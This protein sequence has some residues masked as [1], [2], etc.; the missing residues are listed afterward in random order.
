MYKIIQN[1][2]ELLEIEKGWDKLAKKFSHPFFSFNWY[3]S[4]ISSFYNSEDVYILVTYDGK[5][6]TGIAPLIKYGKNKISHL[7]IAGY[8]SHFEPCSLLY[9]DDKSKNY[10]LS[11]LLSLNVPI[12][13][14]RIPE[15]YHLYD[16]LKKNSNFYTFIISRKG[17]K[18]GVVKVKEEWSQRYN[19][20][21][22]RRRYQFRRIRKKISE[23]GEIKFEIVTP[24]IDQFNK[25]FDELLRIEGS[26]WK[27]QENT[28]LK[29]EPTLQK[30]YKKYAI[31]A[32]ETN[33]LRF[34]ILYLSD[35]I[36]AISMC[37][38]EYKSLWELKIGYD[39]KWAKYSPGSQL[40]FEKMRYTYQNNL[41]S[42]EFLGSLDN[43]Q[44]FWVNEVR[45]YEFVSIY[46]SNIRGFF[47]FSADVITYLCKCIS[48]KT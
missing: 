1:K 34:F 23:Y 4:A 29:Y 21:S 39:D 26:G 30:F 37:V 9:K 8:T 32:C 5:D 6:I 43:W 27:G 31:N 11:C 14:H 44:L 10:L 41:K 19:Q 46:P 18:S 20:F 40:T 13:L 47:K 36:I 22:S 33:S 24:N 16:D 28:A 35:K 2:Q 45:K 25:Y 17:S 38:E 42:Y 48:R 12:L 15:K 3:Y 7:E